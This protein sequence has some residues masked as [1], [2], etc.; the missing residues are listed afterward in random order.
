MR[1]DSLLHRD[2]T[3]EYP[4]IVRGEGIY[5]YDSEG[6]RYVDGIS[7]A[8]NVILGHGR[9]RIAA[10]MAEQAATLAYCFSAFF[11]NQPALDLAARIASLAPGDLNHVYFVSG[12]SEGIETA[13]KL[14][15]QYHLQ[16]GNGQK[17]KIISR[18]GSYHGATLGALA[19]TGLP[20]LRTPFEPWLA[21]FPH[22][23][24]CYP[25]RCSLPGCEGECDLACA[26]QLAE[27]IR[28]EG[29][30]TVAAFVAEPVVMAGMAAGVPPPGYFDEI[31]AI[32]DEFDVLFIADE[33]ITGFGRTGRYFAIEHWG[34]VPDIIVIGKGASGGYSPLGGVIMRDEIYD[35]FSASGTPFAHVFTYVNNPVAMRV[36]LEVL[37]IIE[38]EGLLEHATQVGEYLHR[39]ARELAVHPIVGDV[40]GKGMMLGIEVVGDRETKE[41][42]AA[43]LGVSKRLCKIALSKGLAVSG[44]SG[45]ADGV[46]GDDLRFYPP[47]IIT[48]D[49]VD[50]ALTVIDE[51]LAQ[52]EREEGI[53]T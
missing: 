1:R 39:R 49:Q 19:A 8:G 44:V 4:V 21:D 38:E 3:Y 25:Y 50:E 48:R 31:R 27:I 14:S 52:V 2:P 10:T 43:D 11:T 47:L 32:C 28:R 13:L 6:R 9:E 35:R 41:P 16:R 26:R 12:G 42:F 24:P 51:S 22:I 5:L 30:E 33:I 20:A 45:S 34:V 46:N 17:H 29:P 37:D 7:G 36:G 53:S 23:A 18:W 15:R 40:R